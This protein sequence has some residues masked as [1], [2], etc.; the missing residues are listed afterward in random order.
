MREQIVDVRTPAGD[1]DIHLLVVYTI[2][3][4]AALG[5]NDRFKM[6]F[7]ITLIGYKVDIQT[8]LDALGQAVEYVNKSVEFGFAFGYR[9]VYFGAQYQ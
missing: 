7:A 4:A 1:F 5:R 9:A 6:R 2:A 3:V 8:L